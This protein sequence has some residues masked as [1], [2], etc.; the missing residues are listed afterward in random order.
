MIIGTLVFAT[1]FM[2]SCNLNMFVT[3]LPASFF[4]LNFFVTGIFI[5]IPLVCITIQLLLILYVIRHPRCQLISLFI[6]I[7]FGALSWL[8]IIP[9]DL[10]LISRYESDTIKTR[11]EATSPGIFRKEESGVYYYSKINPNGTAEGI[12][13]DTTGFLGQEGAALPLFNEPVK[14]ESSFPYSDILIKNS[15]QPPQLVTYPLS[16]YNALL[17][18]AQYSVSQGFLAWLTFATLGLALLS[19]YGIQFVSSWKLANVAYVI[20]S[21]MA[22]L[23]VNYLHYMNLMPSVLKEIAASLSRLTG[24]KDSLLIA[25]NL[26]ITAL[27]AAS[28]TFMGIY[29]NKDNSSMESNE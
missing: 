29:R 28:G 10:K 5:S 8:V 4:S 22:V 3:G 20:C 13:L 27:C 7:L 24:I 16:I 26:A 14:N 19:V 21:A 25:I 1:L 11:V 9:T 6:Y 17:T 23:L 2:F 12:F 18:A 15:L